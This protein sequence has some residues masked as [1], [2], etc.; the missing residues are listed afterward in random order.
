[1]GVGYAGGPLQYVPARW[2]QFVDG[3]NLTIRTQKLLEGKSIRLPDSEDYKRDCFF[4]PLQHANQG[5]GTRPELVE[6]WPFRSCYYTSCVGDD[7]T[8]LEVRRQLRKLGFEPNAFKKSSRATKTKGVDIALT[9]DML[10]HAFRGNYESA[11]LVAGDGDYVPLVEE[12]K[13]LGKRVHVR[14]MEEYTDGELKLSADSFQ[15]I[16][17]M[18]VLFA[19]HKLAA[20]ELR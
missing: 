6:I 16:S 10:S 11:I 14:F 17:E 20:Q 19:T 1:M 13:R 5:F 18:V 3:E 2:M 9:K 12:V 4:V 15:D 7:S 8:L